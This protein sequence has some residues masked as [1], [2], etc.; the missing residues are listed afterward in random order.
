MRKL[1]FPAFSSGPKGQPR[2]SVANRHPSKCDWLGASRVPYGVEDIASNLLESFPRGSLSLCG[3]HSEQ[4]RG[5]LAGSY[6][7]CLFSL[8]SKRQEG[9]FSQRFEASLD[10]TG[11]F[12]VK[13]T[14]K[15][16][17]SSCFFVRIIMYHE[18][19]YYFLLI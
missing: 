18:T 15:T 4:R 17:D 11:G 8:L 3:E 7:A 14:T 9:G 16:Q 1:F 12:C 13:T 2:V 6:E 10:N 19:K 5:L